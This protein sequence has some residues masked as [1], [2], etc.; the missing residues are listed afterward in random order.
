MTELGWRAQ[1]EDNVALFY[2]Q[3][4]GLRDAGH[5]GAHN[6]CGNAPQF[7]INICRRAIAPHLSFDG[8]KFQ[9]NRFRLPMKSMQS[10]LVDVGEMIMML[11]LLVCPSVM[12]IQSR[13]SDQCS[14]LLNHAHLINYGSNCEWYISQT[15]PSKSEE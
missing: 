13:G 15:S 6:R 9:P 11:G 5:Q 3:V 14:G 4:E 10:A 12:P 2:P 1:F 8:T 7:G